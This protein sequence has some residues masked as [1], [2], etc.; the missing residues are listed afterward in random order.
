VVSRPGAR[1]PHA[2]AAF[3]WAALCACEALS[4]DVVV[5]ER[6]RPPRPAPEEP[7]R[8]HTWEPEDRLP[9]PVDPTGPQ[10]FDRP[11]I[12]L[13]LVNVSQVPRAWVPGR[14]GTV[15]MVIENDGTDLAPSTSIRLTLRTREPWID[16][17]EVDTWVTDPVPP[18]VA[19]TIAAPVVLHDWVPSASFAF[20]A[21]ID[22]DDVVDETV[23]KDNV[24]FGHILD[25]T[26]VVVSPPRLDFGVAPVGCERTRRLVIENH[27]DERVLVSSLDFETRAAAD[28][29]VIEGPRLPRN[30]APAG[31]VGSRAEFQV[32]FQPTREVERDTRL[33][34]GTS[35]HY[36]HPLSV[37]VSAA[38]RVAPASSERHR[39]RAGPRID[40]LLVFDRGAS[41]APEVEELKRSVDRWVAELANSGTQY[42]IALT[43]AD[44]EA[45]G[46]AL[47]GPVV[48]SED[49]AP[50][51]DLHAL[52]D[53]VGLEEGA[54]G[55][56]LEAARMSLARYPGW[57]RPDAALMVV[58]VADRDDA[59]LRPV[60][61]YVDAIRSR[62]KDPDAVAAN[63]IVSESIEHCGLPPAQRYL[64]FVDALQG[65]IDPICE[66]DVFESL[67]ARP[68]AGF[69]LQ[70]EF[71]LREPL[72]PETL[73]VRID[74]QL[75][76]PVGP[77]GRDTW[78]FDRWTHVVRFAAPEAPPPGSQIDFEYVAT[79]DALAR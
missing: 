52:L 62:K 15:E 9:A 29:F 4:P 31:K 47:V 56:G 26:P 68:H 2:I 27:A 67:W 48:S 5:G 46:G 58:F 6:V 75:E 71:E 64:A 3:A 70:R 51:R 28:P 1:G 24:W 36:G 40:Y 77:R 73:A 10:T 59:G 20:E 35:A 12:N 17:I 41:M 53:R 8:P 60:S 37:G 30:L 39:Q 7:T 43:L 16:D 55:R 13:R 57:L 23:E 42:R 65:R 21:H 44:P 74:G 79:C 22:P 50:A 34:I 32:R 63:A 38:G 14:E 66:A 33:R 45:T 76:S 72:R 49:V 61:E 18:G 25:V 54:P 11:V 69:G 19:R 78:R